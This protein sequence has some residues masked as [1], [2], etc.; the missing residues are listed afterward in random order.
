MTNKLNLKKL[1][2]I[3]L[4][5]LSLFAL[6]GCTFWEDTAKD[7]QSDNSGLSRTITIYSKKGEVLKRYY[8][9]SV[10]TEVDESGQ[11]K[12]NLDGKR[13]QVMNADVVIEEDGIEKSVID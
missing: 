9:T 8:G 10:R 2:F 4:A 1:T 6:T 5:S 7:W 11:I 3:G 12:I 13:L